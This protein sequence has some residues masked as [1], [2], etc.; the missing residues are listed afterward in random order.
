ML[1]LTLVACGDSEEMSADEEETNTT[2][3]Q[4]SENN[5]EEEESDDSDT[6]FD[7]GEYEYKIK[8]VEQIDGE[9]DT[10]VLAIELEF[11][12]NTDEPISPW[13]SLG[14]TAEQETED[15]VESLDGSN[16]LYPEDYKPD[17]VKMGD[18]DI[19]PGKTVD[20]VI[21]FEI[22]FPGEPVILKDFGMD[23]GELFEK[24]VETEE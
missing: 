23:E 9:Y 21:G 14:I 12:N 20:A 16:G 5:N 18:S 15:T 8:E 7:N 1:A 10:E 22:E 6:Y 13:M 2:E 17:L 11:T 24:V 4:K 19:K 3:I